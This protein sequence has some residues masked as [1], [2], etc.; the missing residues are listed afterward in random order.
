[1]RSGARRH[2]NAMRLAWFAL[3][4]ERA[5][6]A[7]EALT[8]LVDAIERWLRSD[9]L[10]ECTSVAG[11]VHYI[12]KVLAKEVATRDRFLTALL[13]R[14]STVAPPAAA[15]ALSTSGPILVDHRHPLALSWLDAAVDSAERS[16]SA[17]ALVHALSNRGGHRYDAGE[18]EHGLAD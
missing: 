9:D 8:Q 16:G 15:G 7:D 3:A 18:A 4:S 2:E 11:C 14:L 5:E 6:D 13:A 10:D 1:R 17:D 12:C